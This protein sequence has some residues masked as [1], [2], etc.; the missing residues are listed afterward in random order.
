MHNKLLEI[1]I[2]KT[3]NRYSL[4]AYQSSR[5]SSFCLIETSIIVYIQSIQNATQICLSGAW[6]MPPSWLGRDTLFLLG[7][8]CL[9][10]IIQG[11]GNSCFKVSQCIIA[12]RWTYYMYIR[13]G[14][15]EVSEW[16]WWEKYGLMNPLWCKLMGHFKSQWN[17]GILLIIPIPVSIIAVSTIGRTNTLTTTVVVD[18]ICPSQCMESL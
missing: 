17:Y 8:T 15:T 10:H 1:S 6:N 16:L 18:C 7:G 12:V 13:L 4:L 5:Y 9:R 11:H 3:S 2:S 14:I